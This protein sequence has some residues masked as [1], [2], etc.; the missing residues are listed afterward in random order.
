LDTKSLLLGVAVALGIIFVMRRIRGG[1]SLAASPKASVDVPK[2]SEALPG[3]QSR[4]TQETIP[5][6]TPEYV[7]PPAGPGGVSF[8][9]KAGG[10][11]KVIP[12]QG[13]FPPGSRFAKARIK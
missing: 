11:E 1:K 9:G 7:R 13:V 3:R 5:D 4:S 10:G 2:A 8:G 12:T 6:G